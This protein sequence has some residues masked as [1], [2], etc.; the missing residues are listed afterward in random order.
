MYL[1]IPL[2]DFSNKNKIPTKTVQ[3]PAKI[4][5]GNTIINLLKNAIWETN[6]HNPKITKIFL[7]SKLIFLSEYNIVP[8]TR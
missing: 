6:V 4:K 7:N 3:I 2:F 8:L 1:P 5:T